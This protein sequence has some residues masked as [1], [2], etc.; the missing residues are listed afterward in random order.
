[1][2]NLFD[3]SCLLSAPDFQNKSRKLQKF[4]FRTRF[5]FA[6]N[7]IADME[8][9]CERLR[10]EIAD[11]KDQNKHLEQLYIANSI[12]RASTK[13]QKCHDLSGL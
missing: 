2:R 12:A 4:H 8:K 10:R 13:G 6:R 9:A 11:L 3:A 1:M 5:D 7:R